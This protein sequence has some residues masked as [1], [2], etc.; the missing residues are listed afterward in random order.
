MGNY[1]RTYLLR[2]LRGY[3]ATFEKLFRYLEMNFG[4]VSLEFV[5]PAEG[6][7]TRIAKKSIFRNNLVSRYLIRQNNYIQPFSFLNIFNSNSTFKV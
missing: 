7:R 6:V 5:F 1:E 3:L 4:D 2:F